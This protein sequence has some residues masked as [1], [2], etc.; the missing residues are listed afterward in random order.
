MVLELKS[1]VLLLRFGFG[2]HI[3]AILAAL[4]V[5]RIGNRVGGLWPGGSRRQDKQT[6]RGQSVSHQD[7]FDGSDQETDLIPALPSPINCCVIL[8]SGVS[9]AMVT[10]NLTVASSPCNISRTSYVSTAMS[11]TR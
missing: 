6:H 11:R 10:V 3:L 8:A 5:R 7:F 2:N 9:G 4:G 1:K